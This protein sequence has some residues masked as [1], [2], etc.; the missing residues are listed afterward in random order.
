SPQLAKF[1]KKVRAGAR[2]FQ[3]QA[4]YNAETFRQFMMYARD[5]GAKVL[6]GIVVLRS[7]G[8]ARFMNRNIPGIVVPDS[9]IAE[10]EASEDPIQ[11]GIDIAA[12]FIDDV[13]DC[14][15]GIHIMAVG[16]EHLVPRVL[17]AAELRS[18]AT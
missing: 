12:R 5:L 2:F 6:A 16:A 14:C 7:A 4:V 11:T 10:L 15:D 18:V 8:M 13:R 17:D 9:I 3:T 1:E